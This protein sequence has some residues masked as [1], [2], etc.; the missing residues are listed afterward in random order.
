MRCLPLLFWAVFICLPGY[1]QAQLVSCNAE[2]DWA[3]KIICRDTEL[4]LR[5]RA[6]Q[7]A[8]SGAVAG[9]GPQARAQLDIDQ[10]EWR[11]TLSS[12]RTISIEEGVSPKD[13]L[14][15]SFDRR[16]EAIRGARAMN[17]EARLS[18]SVAPAGPAL[19]ATEPKGQEMYPATVAVGDDGPQ[20]EKPLEDIVGQPMAESELSQADAVHAPEIPQAMAESAPVR[21]LAPSVSV[22]SVSPGRIDPL[23]S[24]QVIAECAVAGTEEVESCVRTSLENAEIE[25]Q[26]V[27]SRLE[28]KLREMDVLRERGHSENRLHDTQVDFGT[29]RET[30]CQWMGALA[31]DSFSG[32]ILYEG[33]IVDMTRA[34]ARSLQALYD[35]VK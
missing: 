1:A 34:R 29:F 30:H 18:G 35:M 33:C 28:L 12:C 22:P 9:L 13:C 2:D 17:S 21:V 11:N 15:D 26:I 32:Q 16:I 20:T 31:G 3:G 4:S 5:D 14:L 23:G 27:A 6:L 7:G 24:S 19:L 10:A 8:I 25:L